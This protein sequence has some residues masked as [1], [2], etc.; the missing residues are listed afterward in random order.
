MLYRSVK[1]YSFLIMFMAA[2]S[3]ASCSKTND[4]QTNQQS[5]PET[6]TVGLSTQTL[7]HDNTDREY[8][9]YIPESYDGSA[10]WPL[11]F[12]FHGYGGTATQHMNYTD[13]RP[14]ADTEHF[15]LVYPQGALLDGAP[16]WN[17]G[18]DSKDNKSD[19]DDFGFVEAM[20]NK[21]STDYK[22][23][24]KRVYACGY[25]NGSF[26]SYSL[27]C[28]HSDKIAAI[29]SVAGTMGEET[30][31]QCAPIHPM[32]M[33]NIHGTSDFVVPYDGGFGLTSIPKTIEYWVGFNHTDATPTIKTID[34]NGTTIE[35][36]IY[37]NGDNNTSVEHYK[38][39]KGD[40]VWFDINYE[41]ANTSKLI[42]DFVSRYDINGLRQ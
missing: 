30:N 14:I 19:V 7:V 20:I 25:S 2:I 15:I 16:H 24:A 27:A 42:W 34:D 21:I 41:G 10:D 8:L 18:L 22:V 3:L 33:I 26:F 31:N 4:N 5:E 1:T 36:Y 23:D 28:F 11:M 12:N 9:L 29:G 6:I 38:I 37:A 17:S 40:H 39:I 13:M 32:P 35:H